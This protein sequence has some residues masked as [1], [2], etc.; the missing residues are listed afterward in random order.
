MS[1]N[2]GGI[3]S[4]EMGGGGAVPSPLRFRH[5]WMVILKY[6][7]NV[8]APIHFI[9]EPFD[10]FSHFILIFGADALRPELVG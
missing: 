5:P 1:S 7:P 10:N 4:W 6:L 9:I 2:W 8:D 3:I